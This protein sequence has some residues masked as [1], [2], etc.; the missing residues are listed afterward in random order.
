MFLQNFMFICDIVNLLVCFEVYLVFQWCHAEN[1]V[2]R[3]RRFHT[4]VNIFLLS[5]THHQKEGTFTIIPVYNF[6]NFHSVKDPKSR[7]F[8][9]AEM[10]GRCFPVLTTFVILWSRHQE[11]TPQKSWLL[12]MCKLPCNFHLQTFFS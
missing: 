4:D 10:S 12:I 9:A 11:D 2:S 8:L 5:F 7:I 1:R 6:L 3:Y